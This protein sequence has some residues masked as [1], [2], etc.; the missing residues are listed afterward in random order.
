MTG[1]YRKEVG[2]DI[3]HIECTIADN[4]KKNTEKPP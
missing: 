1:N 4:E 2:K 3:R